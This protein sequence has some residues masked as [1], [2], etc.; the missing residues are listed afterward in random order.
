QIYTLHLH[1]ALPISG[2]IP[3]DSNRENNKVE[4]TTIGTALISIPSGPRKNSSGINATMVVITENN[5][6][7]Y[8]SITPAKAAF[9]PVFPCSCPSCLDSRPITASSSTM[10]S[11]TIKA[12]KE[13]KLIEVAVS[14]STNKVPTKDTRIPTLTQNDS[15]AFRNNSSTINS[16]IRPL[17]ALSS[18]SC[19]RSLKLTASSCQI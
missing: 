13:I 18:S 14:G 8:T 4:I 12:N 7:W 15:C 17:K 16:R 10:P 2:K 19:K 3:R 6:G 1:D 11:T 5:T 9:A